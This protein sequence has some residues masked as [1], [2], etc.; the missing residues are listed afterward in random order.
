MHFGNRSKINALIAKPNPFLAEVAKTEPKVL[1]S[2]HSKNVENAEL[3]IT[4]GE[5]S[6]WYFSDANS[7]LSKKHLSE[8]L[9]E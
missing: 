5:L 2:K 9:F 6:S 7:E 1:L 8:K 3:R 4:F